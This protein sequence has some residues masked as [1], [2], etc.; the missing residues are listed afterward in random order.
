MRWAMRAL[1]LFSTVI[2]ARI[3]SPEDFGVVAIAL[4]AVGLLETV[5]YLGVDLSLIKDQSAGRDEFDTA[6][7]IQLLQGGLIALLLFACSPL[8]ASFFNEPR[9]QAVIAWLALRPILEGFQNIGLVTFRRDLKF[10]QEFR[11]ASKEDLEVK[12]P[13]I[14]VTPIDG[15]LGVLQEVIKTLDENPLP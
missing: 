3:L 12:V 4:I 9:A 1:G 14:H 15:C 2:V 6:W 7:T 13:V 5:A 10:S 8:A 11:F